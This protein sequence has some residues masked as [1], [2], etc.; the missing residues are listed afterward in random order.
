MRD[1]HEA[2]ERALLNLGHTFGHA[3]ERLTGYDG[4][5]LVHGEGVA[6][7]MAMAFRFSHR[8][9]LCGAADV[10]RVEAHLAAA[11]LPVHAE[12]IAGFD[13]AP[14]A[15]LDAMRQDKKVERGALTFILVKG[16]GRAF[17]AKGIASDEVLAFLEEELRVERTRT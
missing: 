11:G 6:I 1:E 13:A 8:L 2:G 4:T 14:E 12:A 7:G 17:I 10:A 16:I 5:R 15:M 9:G 3:L